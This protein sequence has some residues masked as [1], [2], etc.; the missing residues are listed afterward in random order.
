MHHAVGLRVSLLDVLR[1]V[2]WVLGDDLDP[3][4]IC[5][6]QYL[7]IVMCAATPTRVKSEGDALHAAVGQ[8]LLELVTGV[9]ETLASSLDVVDGDGNVTK[10]LVRVLVAIL[11][12]EAWVILGAVVVCEFNQACMHVSLHWT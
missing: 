7:V 10:A 3:V 2:D 6:G 8:F 11:D 12:L 4:S 1:L 5:C 9:L